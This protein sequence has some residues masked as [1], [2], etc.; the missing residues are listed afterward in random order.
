MPIAFHDDES[1]LLLGF[2]GYLYLELRDTAAYAAVLFLNA[3]GEP[4]EFVYNKLELLSEALWRRDDRAH[5]AARRLCAS[6]FSTATLTPR[7]LLFATEN[8][9][10]QVFGDEGGI[11]LDV[12]VGAVSGALAGGDSG[13]RDPSGGAEDIHVEWFPAP[14]RGELLPLLARRGLLLEPFARANLGLREVYAEL[15]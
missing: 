10:R 2:A 1:V 5:G 15:A 14:P 13:D 3:R 12:P 6:L 9:P 4:Q 7:F 8:F 11:R